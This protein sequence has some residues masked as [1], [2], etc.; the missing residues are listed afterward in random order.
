MTA[1]ALLSRLQHV[2]KSGTGRWRA[3]CPA[4]S[5]GTGNRS[6]LSIY[7]TP[8]GAVLLRCHA[9]E[10]A[11]SEIAGAVGLDLSELFP[12]RA[13]LEKGGKPIAKPWIARDVLKVLDMDLRLAYVLFRDIEVGRVPLNYTAEKAKT[14]KDRIGR[15]ISELDRAT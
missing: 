4:H 5:G 15:L 1:E 13:T 2:R 14:A 9:F 10:C 11:A 3:Q 8:D 6:A 7:E 12:P